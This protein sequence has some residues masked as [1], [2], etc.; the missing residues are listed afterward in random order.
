MAD[1]AEEKRTI[2]AR[3]SIH[4]NGTAATHFWTAGLRIPMEW[5]TL[6]VSEEQL[7]QL[8][9]ER[10]KGQVQ[11]REPLPPPVVIPIVRPAPSKKP[12]RKARA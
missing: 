5:T 8:E 12:V 6:E 9:V 4:I 2:E 7:A 1:E 10:D 11:M 3:C